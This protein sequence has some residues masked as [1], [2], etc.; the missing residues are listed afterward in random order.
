VKKSAL[1]GG[2][3]LLFTSVPMVIRGSVAVT[4]LLSVERAIEHDVSGV[5]ELRTKQLSDSRDFL[6]AKKDSKD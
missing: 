2:E 6:S 3:E 5:Y 4:S 1:D